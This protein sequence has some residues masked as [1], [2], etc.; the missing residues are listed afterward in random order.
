MKIKLALVCTIIAC[1]LAAVGCSNRGSQFME[2]RKDIS[3]TQSEESDFVQTGYT[4]I[5]NPSGSD[6]QL[7]TFYDKKTGVEYI[8]LRNG[9]MTSIQ[10][11]ISGD[12]NILLHKAEEK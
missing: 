6:T 5:Y 3:I 1:T 7:V 4:S 12:G 2:Q 8:M 9:D 11:R 10:P